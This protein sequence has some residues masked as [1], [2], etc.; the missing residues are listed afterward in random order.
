MRNAITLKLNEEFGVSRPD[1]LADHIMYC[2]P[3]NTMRSVAYAYI[4]SWNSVFND[5][6]CLKLSA[7]MHEIGHNLNLGHSNEIDSYVDQSGMVSPSI[8]VHT[9]HVMHKLIFSIPI[10]IM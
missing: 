3:P 10:H 1:Q 4:N 7:Q 5:E 6:W 9:Y 8:N 2:L